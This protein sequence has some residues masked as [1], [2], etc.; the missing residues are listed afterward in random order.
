MCASKY[1]FRY[2]SQ[3]FIF[4]WSQPKFKKKGSN[5]P[6]Q[7]LP[8]QTTT[9]QQQFKIHIGYSQPGKEAMLGGGESWMKNK[10]RELLVY[11]HSVSTPTFLFM[12]PT[13][14]HLSLG[15]CSIWLG[16]CICF[17]LLQA[18]HVQLSSPCSLGARSQQSHL[19]S[20]SCSW[21]HNVHC[22]SNS[23][24]S[25]W[26]KGRM[27][28]ILMQENSWLQWSLNW[29]GDPAESSAGPFTCFGWT[30][31]EPLS[32]Q[33]IT[34]VT[35]HYIPMVRYLIQTSKSIAGINTRAVLAQ[36][37]VWLQ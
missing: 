9:H 22:S 16:R 8:K 30:M 5:E 21:L 10:T 23:S 34:N 26:W 25:I 27:K 15:I 24:I 37:W 1:I 12:L 6:I 19:W 36:E 2:N 7:V 20:L 33:T 35:P 13:L 28:C 4:T 18:L 3:I 11:K 14:L 29:L 17:F 31:T 32:H